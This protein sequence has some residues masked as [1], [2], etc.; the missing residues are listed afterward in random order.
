V[1]FF[2]GEVLKNIPF[3]ESDYNDEEIFEYFGLS[4]EGVLDSKSA[5]SFCGY[6]YYI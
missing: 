1:V 4:K 3:I 2:H 5:K 6:K